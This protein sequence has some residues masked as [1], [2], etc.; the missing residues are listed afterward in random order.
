MKL[1]YK[2]KS[3]YLVIP[4]TKCAKY[5]KKYTNRDIKNQITI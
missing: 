4:V 5:C 2:E 3:L 1:L